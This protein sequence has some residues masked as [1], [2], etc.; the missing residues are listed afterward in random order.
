MKLHALGFLW[1]GL[2]MVA[3]GVGGC[4][5]SGTP[6]GSLTG[7]VV[8]AEG[9]PVAGARINFGYTILLGG[10]TLATPPLAAPLPPLTLGADTVTVSV[11]DHLDRLVWTGTN[12]GGA[13]LY[14]DGRNLDGD[15][16]PDGPY[17]YTLAIRGDGGEQS[18]E[19]WMILVQGNLA[20]RAETAV[21]VTGD[22]GFFKIPYPEIPIWKGYPI[23]V[24]GS[25]PDSV[26][27][28]DAVFDNT[29]QV[30]A[31]RGDGTTVHAQKTVQ[32]ENRYTSTHVEFALP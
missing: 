25:D 8:D 16:I 31:F 1:L 18:L 6:P 7:T 19:R 5:D 12:A 3:A 20:L 2:G 10:D 13:E 17:R 4:S 22:D 14:W 26:L 24:A 30:Y 9:A 27:S 29:F 23:T 21:A 32:V 28:G 15:P 11:F